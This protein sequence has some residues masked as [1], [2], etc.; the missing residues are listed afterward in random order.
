M[1]DVVIVGAGPAGAVAATI[2]GRAGVRVQVLDRARFPRDKLC[3][4]SVNPGAVAVLRRLGLDTTLASGLAI[5]GMRVS[6]ERVQVEASYEGPAGCSILRRDLDDALM[7]AAG[8][9]GAQ[10]EEGALVQEPVVDGQTR[11][12]GVRVRGRSGSPTIGGRL[13]IAADGRHS[14]V[15]R[16]L[17]ISR[18]ADRPQRW[19][20]GAYFQGVTGLTARGEMHVRAGHYI[21]VAP[22]PGGRANACVVT[23]DRRA[24]RDASSLLP[25]VLR[26]D[27]RLA[28]RFASAVQVTPAVCLGPLAVEADAAGMEGL[29]LAGD[30][31]G[32]V[33]PM[34]G[35]GLRFAFEGGALAASE[36][37]HALEHG[38]EGAHVRLARARRE[39]FARKW[40]F[41]RV[42][43]ALVSSPG[44]VSAAS[45]GAALMPGLLRHLVRYAGDLQVAA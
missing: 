31:A 7:R 32:F 45:L 10:I 16:A 5:D 41:N 35:D 18:S 9:A 11:V 12:T 38:I 23:A 20:V 36:A 29:L 4:D 25:R 37:L 14:R 43:R 44:A 24:L 3:G 21:G 8:A 39:A 27:P 26:R 2:L 42:L 6:S 34:T 13:V 1:H 22:V 33:D 15:A 30:A 17:G 40:R 19:A 28:P